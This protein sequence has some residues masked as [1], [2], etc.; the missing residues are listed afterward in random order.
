MAL[1]KA[2]AGWLG[3]V[4]DALTSAQSWQARGKYCICHRF[5]HKTSRI[6]L[7]KQMTSAV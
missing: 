5:T 7:G 4:T 6:E 1:S 2:G 3:D